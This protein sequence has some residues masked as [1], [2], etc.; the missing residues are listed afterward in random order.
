M[1]LFATNSVELATDGSGEPVTATALTVPSVFTIT[2]EP[3]ASV[4][5]AVD[6]SNELPDGGR[7]SSSEPSPLSLVAVTIPAIVD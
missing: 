5:D 1:I 4:P 7:L 3:S 6:F 2:V